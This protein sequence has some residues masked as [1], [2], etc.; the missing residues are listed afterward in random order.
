MDGITLEDMAS[1]EGLLD[2]QKQLIEAV[3]LL[4]LALDKQAFISNLIKVL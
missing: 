4:D 1:A 2:G 3:L